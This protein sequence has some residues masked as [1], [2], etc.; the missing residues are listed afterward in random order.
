MT[1]GAIRWS[2][3][4]NDVAGMQTNLAWETLLDLPATKPGPLH[5]RLAAAIRTAIRDGRIP[6]E[7][8]L[9]PSR[10][11]AADLRVS[12]WTVTQAYAQLVTEGYLTA[13]T[14]SATRVSWASR[15]GLDEAADLPVRPP[16]AV[17]DRPPRFDLSSARPDLRAFPRRKWV[18]AIRAAAETAPF[19]Q[20]DYAQ[21]GGHPRLRAVLA[22][23]LNRSRGAAAEPATISVFSGA[24]QSMSQ[25][26][27]AL[28][29]DGQVAIGV[30]DPGSSRLWQAARTAG[31]EL[32][33]LPVDDDGLVVDELEKHPGLR[34]VCVGA[35]RQVATGCVL[36]PHRRSALLDWARRVRRPGRRGRLRLGV[37]LLRARARGHAGDGPAAGGAARV[38]EPDA[39]SDR[40]HRLGGRPAPV[41]GGCPGGPRDSG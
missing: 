37:Q 25:V 23:H 17:P 9:P 38:G 13:R 28:L 27:H 26:S 21:S 1:L 4:S 39:Q 14:G 3:R 41:G 5:M 34:A 16:E 31:L 11:L 24:G 40:R 15:P 2:L 12:R 10:T 35:A 36:A 8:A 29:A 6:R 32:V 30:E 33:G 20:L 19:D 18:E 22:E 7:A